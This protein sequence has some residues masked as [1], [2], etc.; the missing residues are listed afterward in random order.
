MQLRG[1]FNVWFVLSAPV[2]ENSCTPDDVHKQQPTGDGSKGKNKDKGEKDKEA[3]EEKPKEEDKPPRGGRYILEKHFGVCSL[4]VSALTGCVC[5]P[6]IYLCC[7]CD[8]RTVCECVS[9]IYLLSLSAV[10]DF[11]C[12]VCC[13]NC[14]SLHQK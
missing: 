1:W 8:A 10:L 2:P 5:A 14:G 6:C 12:Y 9:C 4:I 13:V 3:K 7:P 11:S